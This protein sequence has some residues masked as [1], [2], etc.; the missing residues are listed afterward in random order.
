[1]VFRRNVILSFILIGM[2]SLLSIG[3]KSEGP[4]E[5]AGEKVDQAIDDASKVGG[6]IADEASDGAKDL[7]DK[8]EDSK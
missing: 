7:A 6:G 2:I 1:M 5:K 8:V 3:C 4:I